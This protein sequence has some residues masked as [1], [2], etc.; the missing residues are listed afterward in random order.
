MD[1]PDQGSWD[2]RTQQAPLVGGGE[3]RGMTGREEERERERV[4]VCK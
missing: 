4:C 1:S 2:R 3:G